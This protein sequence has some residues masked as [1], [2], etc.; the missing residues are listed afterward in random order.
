MQAKVADM[1][2]K[3]AKGNEKENE[4]PLVIN[5]VKNGVP[6]PPKIDQ[7]CVENSIKNWK[8]LPEDVYVVGFMRSGTTWTQQILKLNIRNNGV[9]DGVE[10]Q[11]SVPWIETT[12]DEWKVGIHT[13]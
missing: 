2:C 9:D 13:P 8:L 1:L 7:M 12:P 10:L 4:C 6:Y 11:N 5:Y 3:Q